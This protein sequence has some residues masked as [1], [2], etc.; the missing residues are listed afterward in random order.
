[1]K[2]QRS[3]LFFWNVILLAVGLFA[4]SSYALNYD[5]S[6][7]RDEIILF[8]IPLVI[9]GYVYGK[10][11]IG[12]PV[13]Q[14]RDNLS[15]HD[16]DHYS[17]TIDIK[18]PRE[19][20]E[21]SEAINLMKKNVINASRFIKSIENG[22]LDV[23]YSENGSADQESNDNAGKSQGPLEGAL[24]SMRAKMREIAKE[25]KERNWVTE[26]LAK[27]I[28]L[29]RADNDDLKGL[30]DKIISNLVKYTGVNQGGL[31][32]ANRGQEEDDKE[33]GVLELVACYAYDRKKFL[34]RKVK[35]S[36]LR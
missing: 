21:I 8:I 14:I 27:F 11:I 7:F 10:R 19:L 17:K 29:L 18:R 30:S 16:A 1:M 9:L 23:S 15:D 31:F 28:D 36:T 22:E 12:K 13:H 20:R 3:V 32:I 26:G 2:K 34:A 35:I 33:D 5:A 4:L 6:T 24:L 25:D